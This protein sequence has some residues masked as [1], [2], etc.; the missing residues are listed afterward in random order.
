MRLAHLV[1]IAH[2]NALIGVAEMQHDRDAGLLVGGDGDP[3]AVIA[4]GTGDALEARRRKIGERAAPAIADDRDLAGLCSHVDGRLDVGEGTVIADRSAQLAP[5]G[6]GG[7]VI[8]ELDS[9]LGA[10]E[11]GRRDGEIAL[12]GETVRDPAHVIVD[13]KD[14]LHD[15]N[16]T[17]RLAARLGAVGGKFVTVRSREFDRLPHIGLHLLSCGSDDHRRWRQAAEPEQH[18]FPANQSRP[19]L[20]RSS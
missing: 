15:D 17:A 18:T 10:V 19:P 14:L 9:A 13:A 3:A 2:R 5:A 1:D 6:D 7:L 8:P 20:R 4:D 16:R 11:E 12:R